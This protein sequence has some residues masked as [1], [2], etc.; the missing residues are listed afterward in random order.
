MKG[1][2][3]SE[4]PGSREP[5]GSKRPPRLQKGTKGLQKGAAMVPLALALV[6][7]LPSL[8][9]PSKTIRVGAIFTEDQ[10]VKNIKV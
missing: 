3:G 7:L 6:A 4:T 10:K 5:L 8:T 1:R 2:F 9:L